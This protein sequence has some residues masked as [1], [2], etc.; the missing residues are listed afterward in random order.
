MCGEAE[1]RSFRRSSNQLANLTKKQAQDGGSTSGSGTKRKRVE[2]LTNITKKPAGVSTAKPTGGIKRKRGVSGWKLPS[3][4]PCEKPP[5]RVRPHTYCSKEGCNVN[6]LNTP[7]TRFHRIKKYPKPLKENAVKRDYVNREGIIL[8]RAEILDRCDFKRNV[9]DG[10]YR[11]CE[12][13]EF[14]W[15]VKPKKLSWK[16]KEWTQLFNLYVPKGDGAKAT[17]CQET[18]GSRGTAIDRATLRQLACLNKQIENRPNIASVDTNSPAEARNDNVDDD[19]AEATADAAESR[20]AVQQMAE[21]NC[22]DTN[23]GVKMNASV[24]REVGLPCDTRQSPPVKTPN[25]TFFNANARI[26]PS[27]KEKCKPKTFAARRSPKVKLGMPDDEVNV[28]AP[29]LD[30]PFPRKQNGVDL[31]IYL[32]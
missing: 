7:H 6:N 2:E 10:A 29:Y 13:H 31:L 9:K 32:A 16:G 18:S 27:A 28:T 30:Q 20:K 12:E 17:M 5:P 15:A 26:S 25:K 22:N 14:E 4:P 23:P 11:V 24:A 19:V 1:E 3:K 8:L 21:V